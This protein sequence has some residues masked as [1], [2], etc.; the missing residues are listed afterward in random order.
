VRHHQI[1]RI[2]NLARDGFVSHQK[3]LVQ[4]PCPR[5]HGKAKNRRHRQRR[6]QIF[7]PAKRLIAV[8]LHRQRQR[9]NIR[10]VIH[11]R[12]HRGEYKVRRG[13]RRDKHRNK[14]SIFER[15]IKKRHHQIDRKNKHRRRR[16]NRQR[17]RHICFCQ[18]SNQRGG[19]KRKN[20]VGQH[21]AEDD[22][23]RRDGRGKQNRQAAVDLF[24]HKTAGEENADESNRQDVK[25]R[26]QNLGE[27]GGRRRE[28]RD[29]NLFGLG[30][31][32]LAALGIAARSLILSEVVD[33]H[34]QRKSIFLCEGISHAHQFRFFHVLF[35]RPYREL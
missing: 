19:A 6:E 18:H 4:Q 14:S 17:Q 35:Q 3:L 7:A 13:H 10:K 12:K 15:A 23:K 8:H 33:P 9:R 25:Q 22:L 21:L 26:D 28:R 27:R 20:R 5:K 16:K 30:D 24:I 31:W 2:G 11:I 1:N 32:S 34:P 29:D